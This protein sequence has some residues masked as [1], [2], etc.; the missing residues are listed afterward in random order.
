MMAEIY[1]SND[2]WWQFRLY[3]LGL[4]PIL[5]NQ[6][7]TFAHYMCSLDSFLLPDL[8]KE[9]AERMLGALVS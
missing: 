3:I 9:Q 8:E 5:P 7:A 6:D 4:F 1:R 2:I